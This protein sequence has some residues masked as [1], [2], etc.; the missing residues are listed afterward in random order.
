MKWDKFFQG[1]TFIQGAKLIPKSRVV[2]HGG[3][4]NPA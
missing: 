2:N 4:E 3:S 1:A